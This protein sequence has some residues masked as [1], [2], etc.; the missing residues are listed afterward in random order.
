[1]EF[2]PPP[3]EA[4]LS[5]DFESRRFLLNPSPGGDHEAIDDAALSFMD[6]MAGQGVLLYEMLGEEAQLLMNADGEPDTAALLDRIRANE[7]IHSLY[8]FIST[9]F[10]LED[11]ATESD[12]ADRRGRAFFAAIRTS[13]V[14]R[15]HDPDTFSMYLKLVEMAVE[16][17]TRE[18]FHDRKARIA[19]SRGF[20]PPQG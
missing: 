12:Q 11:R 10:V 15:H 5:F 3:D 1:M 7:S 6:F 4:P 18:R 8:G 2:V 9:G 19:R 17:V 14:A 20:Y 13:K 16:E